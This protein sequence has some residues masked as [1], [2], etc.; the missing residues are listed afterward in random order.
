MSVQAGDDFRFRSIALPALLPSLLFGIGEGAIIPI[1]PAVASSLGAGL[2]GAGFIA[3]MIVVGQLAGDIPSGWLV[4]KIG[5][6]VAMISAA[7]LSIASVTVAMFAATATLFGVAI[8]FLGLSAAVFALARQAFMTT[9]VPVRIRARA[10]STLGGSFRAGWFIGPFLGAAVIGLTGSVQAAFL[11]HITCAVIVTVVLIAMPDP[12]ANVA[13]PDAGELLVRAESVSLFTTIWQNRGVLLRMGSGAGV[14]GALRASRMAIL[15]LWAVSIGLSESST[16]LIV[17]IGAAADFALFYTS[18]QIMDRFGRLWS[19]VPSMV[20][21]GLALIT[22]SFT[23]DLPGAVQ[24]FVVVAI[25]MG[26]ANGVGSGIIMTLSADLAPRDDPAPFL[27]AF[28]FTADAGAAAAPL[29]V[30]G[31]VAVA[32]L[33]LATGLVGVVGLVGAGI[34]IRNVPRYLPHIPRAAR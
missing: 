22:L 25:V 28:R 11:L 5:E 17:G 23:H 4:S 19:V 14:V 8:F 20:G 29:V 31:I 6:R 27:G 16:A 15:P 21:M 2:A 34:L 13:K 30:S 33:S 12:T 7:V 18:G 26:V 1:I 32:S 24:W 10:L 3:A 9:F